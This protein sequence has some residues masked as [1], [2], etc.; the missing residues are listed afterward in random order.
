MRQPTKAYSRAYLFR[1]Y[2]QKTLPTHLDEHPSPDPLDG[3]ELPA[4]EIPADI[5]NRWP[6]ATEAVLDGGSEVLAELPIDHDV[7]VV[8]NVPGGRRA[9]LD[10]LEVFL[11]EHI[12]EYAD[13][14][15]HPD[16][17]ASSHLSPYLHFGHVSTHEIFAR[18]AEREG[19]SSDDLSD[20]TSG[21]RD[22]WWGMSEGAEAFLDELVTWREIGFNMCVI[23]P[24]DYDRYETLPDW[25][26][27]TLEEHA[28]DPREYVYDL[29]QFEHAATHDELWN[30]AQNQLRVEGR[31]HNYLRMLWGKK[32]LHWS[33]SPHVA[34]EYM[35]ELNNKYALDGRDPNSYSGIFWVLGRYDRAWGPERPIFGKVRYM[36]CRSAR[37]KLRLDSYLAKFRP[38]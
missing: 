2:L 38:E 14:R 1:K 18:I 20:D 31:I 23:R 30:A 4:G 10:R 26:R 32:I 27:K 22:G 6:H 9:A 33:E 35:I 8:E 25:A 12:D 16:D 15:N 36:T 13:G 24:D 21:S 3:L 11:E 34:L 19:W 37:R 28:D 17:D 29:E 5:L 7:R